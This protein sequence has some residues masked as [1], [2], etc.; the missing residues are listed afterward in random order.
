MDAP[1]TPPEK[2]I[3]ATRVLAP[4]VVPSFAEA[5]AKLGASKHE[6]VPLELAAVQALAQHLKL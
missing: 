3:L 5:A 6:L 1:L 4:G 2:A